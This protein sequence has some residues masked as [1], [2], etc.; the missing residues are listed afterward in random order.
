MLIRRYLAIQ[1]GISEFTGRAVSWLCLALILALLYEVV[2]RY[3]FASPTSW[4][5]ELGTMLYGSFGILAGA[6]THKHRGHV[7]S[8]VIYG[9]FPRKGRA[10]LDILTGLLGLIVFCVFFMQVF[11]FARDSW[12]IQEVSAKSR[13]APPLY[14]FKSVLPLA[15]ALLILQSLAQLVRDICVLLDIETEDDP[16]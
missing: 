8:E 14:P 13:W 11:E 16:S 1:D 15:A 5:H 7:R 12:A 4:A 2:A 9:L 3:F 6:Y 10:L